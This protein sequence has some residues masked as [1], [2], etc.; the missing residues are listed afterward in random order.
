MRRARSSVGTCALSKLLSRHKLLF[1][2]QFLMSQSI[3][4]YRIASLLRF[5]WV[6]ERLL[7]SFQNLVASCVLEPV[8]FSL[9]LHITC[10]LQFVC[11]GRLIFSF[12]FMI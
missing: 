5:S 8:K 7:W 11:C 6:D 12:F 2:D 10:V 9:L 4:G 1:S 3:L